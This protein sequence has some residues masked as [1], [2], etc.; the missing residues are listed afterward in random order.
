MRL[1]DLAALIARS[2]QIHLPKMDERRDIR[3]LCRTVPAYGLLYAG[4]STFAMPA[5]SITFFH[6]SVSAAIS[7]WVDWSRR[8]NPP[9]CFERD[10]GLRYA[11]PPYEGTAG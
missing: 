2:F 1:R 7:A 3:V 4:Y 10:S 8:R 9:L 5:P 11:N 6:F